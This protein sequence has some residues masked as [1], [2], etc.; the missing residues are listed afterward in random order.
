MYSINPRGTICYGIDVHKFF[1]V[2]TIG[3][4]DI[5]GV[6]TYNSNNFYTCNKDL[7]V[8]KDWLKNIIVKIFVRN[9]PVSTGFQ[10]LIILKIMQILL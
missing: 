4:T 3:T 6:T 7:L 1:I 10:Y 9:L 2:A 5:H 8:F